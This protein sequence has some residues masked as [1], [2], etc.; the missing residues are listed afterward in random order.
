ML[1]RGER[2]ARRGDRLERGP[3]VGRRPAGDDR[4]RP[5]DPASPASPTAS[6][7]I[8]IEGKSEGAYHLG[9]SAGHA[10]PDFAGRSIAVATL[11]GEL[12]ILSGAGNVKWRTTLNRPAMA[13]ETDALGRYVVYGQATGEV[14][15]L[16]LQATGRAAPAVSTLVRLVQERGVEVEDR[17]RLGPGPRVDGGGRADRGPGRVRRASP[18]PTDPTRIGVITHKNRLEL[19]GARRQAARP[20]PGD[21]RRRPDR[22]DGAR[23]DGGG[24]RSADRPLRPEAE[25]GPAAST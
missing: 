22:P 6:S 7:G 17:Q 3:D 25:P 14:V 12:A 5:D 13:L 10:V 21:R 20:G 24:D 16:D 11:E 8:D 15:R 23:L 19:F 4:R 18:S 1:A 9:G 2:L